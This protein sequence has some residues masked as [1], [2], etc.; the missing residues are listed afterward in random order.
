MTRTDKTND[1]ERERMPYVQIDSNLWAVMRYP[2]D[3]PV[4]MIVGLA[5]RDNVPLFFVQQWHPEPSKRRVI[6]QHDTLEAANASVLW[7]LE[8]VN[9]AGRTRVGPP[10]GVNA[11]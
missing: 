5:N 10:N 8:R 2:K 6:S 9:A 7:D 11:A 4:A 1:I 3:R